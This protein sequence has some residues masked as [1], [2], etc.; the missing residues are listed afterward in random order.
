MASCKGSQTLA[1]LKPTNTTDPL[2]KEWQDYVNRLLTEEFAR[3]GHRYYPVPD[4][5]RGDGGIEG[6][7]TTGEAFQA[8]A[9]QGSNSTEERA[10][11]QKRKITRDLRKLQDPK[12]QK[13]W[14]ELLNGTPIQR[15]ML[16]VPVIEDKGVLVHARN[17]GEELRKLNLPFLT[18]DFHA[19]VVTA[20]AFPVAEQALTF[21]G[22]GTFPKQRTSATEEELA[23]FETAQAQQI[24]VLDMKLMKLPRLNVAQQRQQ[25][26]RRLLRMHLAAE[27]LLH[28]M[29]R[30]SPTLWQRILVERDEYAQTLE[31]MQGIDAREP[32]TKLRSAV[33]EFRTILLDFTRPPDPARSSTLAL[34][35]VCL[36]LMTCPLDFWEEE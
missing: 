27:N 25:Q 33:D 13:F 32:Q 36:W 8:Y 10:T 20:S 15:W 29:S 3:R 12:R 26:V 7:S 22:L 4:K 11:K 30:Q 23:A 19:T 16:V 2:E 5:V 14:N 31:A 1:N 21:S 28:Q 17:K 34:G 24:A 18:S 9:D 6:F 35:A